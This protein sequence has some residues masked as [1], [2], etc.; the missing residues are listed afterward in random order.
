MGRTIPWESQN[1]EAFL[2]RAEL[3]PEVSAIYAQ[4]MKLSLVT[5]SGERFHFP[6]FAVVIDNKLEIHEV[7]PDEEAAK[8]EVRDLHELAARYIAVNGAIYSVALASVLKADPVYTNLKALVRRLHDCVP[9]PLR[10]AVRDELHKRG[11]LPLVELAER[12]AYWGGTVERAIALIARGALRI[13]MT[14][15]V[16]PTSIAWLPEQFPNPWRLLPLNV[17]LTS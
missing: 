7:K 1:E 14:E 8:K 10:L 12:T 17:P 3:S 4:P 5:D 6:D 15:S 13:E 9:E 2:L 11:P 16:K